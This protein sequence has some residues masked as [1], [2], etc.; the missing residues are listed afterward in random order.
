MK[1]EKLCLL[2]LGVMLLGFVFTPFT[3]NAETL[4]T[5][6]NLDIQVVA[7]NS[8]EMTLSTNQISFNGYN[9][10]QDITNSD[11]NITVSSGLNY[12]INAQVLDEFR[13]VRTEPSLFQ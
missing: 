2:G 10:V 8:L 5:S 11:L 9:G 4:T 13:G 6:K 3:A 1:R 7:D 12:D